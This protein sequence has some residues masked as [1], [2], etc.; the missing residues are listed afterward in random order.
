MAKII[1]RQDFSAP[2]P[3]GRRRA[4]A[5]PVLFS[6]RLPPLNLFFHISQ[7][8]PNF[9]PVFRVEKSEQQ[10]NHAEA[11]ERQNPIR[12]IQPAQI[13]YDGATETECQSAQP[14]QPIRPVAHGEAER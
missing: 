5:L 6:S 2:T 10:Q 14:G 12:Q 4:W 11:D 3:P 8:L 7:P 13:K 1:S 9:L